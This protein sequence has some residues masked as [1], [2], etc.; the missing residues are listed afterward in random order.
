M[1]VGLVI[2]SHSAQLAAGVAELATQ[3]T[4]GATPI[5]PAGGAANDVLGTS[6]DKILAAIQAVDGPDG[7]LILLD[8]GS[9]ILSTEMALEMLEDDQR[10]RIALSFAPLV[11]GTVAASIEASL[12]RTLAEVKAAAEKTAQPEQLQMLKPLSSIAQRLGALARPGRLQSRS[13]LLSR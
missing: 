9:A 1:T 4:Q 12:G 13:L 5:A 10:E 11:E 6:V 8:L 3:M 7:V 2:V